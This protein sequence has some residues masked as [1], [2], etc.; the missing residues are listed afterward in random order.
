MDPDSAHRDRPKI[1][2]AQRLKD[3]YTLR[4]EGSFFTAE[5][6]GAAAGH[7]LVSWDKWPKLHGDIRQ[8]GS[9]HNGTAGQG[10]KQ[11]G[12]PATW[13]PPCP[14]GPKTCLLM[15]NSGR[16]SP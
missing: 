2:R 4:L 3:G 16:R 11:P 5:G 13:R 12:P 6:N 8:N 9:H 15:P 7:V 1:A 14:R 10:P